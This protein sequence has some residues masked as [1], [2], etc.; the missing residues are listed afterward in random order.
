MIID[1]FGHSSLKNDG[2]SNDQGIGPIKEYQAAIAASDSK[3]KPE[4]IDRVDNVAEQQES[5]MDSLKVAETTESA[6]KVEIL[7]KQ[8]NY[9]IPHFHVD[10]RDKAEFNYVKYVLEISGLTGN[11][12]LSAWHSSDQPIDPLLYEEMEG[13]PDFC[14]YE[15]GQCNHHV[16]FDL[17]N[18]TLLEIYGKS[19]CYLPIQL[20]YLPHIH[21]MSVGCHILHQVWTH[22]SKCMRSKPGQTIDDHVNR[23][24]TKHDEWVNLQLCAECVGLELG[25]LDFP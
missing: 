10:T 1:D 15:A 19:Y 18:E 21:P 17:I 7:T 9:E 20:S 11:D 24:L 5:N 3:S 22:M 25:R 8:L 4:S 6:K 16:L 14:T 23:D 13:D 12:C 2:T